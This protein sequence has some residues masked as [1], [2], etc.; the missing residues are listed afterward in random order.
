[1]VRS[2]CEHIL[3]LGRGG[4]WDWMNLVAACRACNSAKADRLPEEAL[5]SSP[6][7]GLSLPCRAANV[8]HATNPTAPRTQDSPAGENLRWAFDLVHS[9]SARMLLATA[10]LQ[11]FAICALHGPANDA[12]TATLAASQACTFS[13]AKPGSEAASKLYCSLF[14]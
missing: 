3:P 10:S 14:N 11:V 6:R 8:I 4:G 5:R 9:F 1:V 2:T 7:Q 13:V 12:A